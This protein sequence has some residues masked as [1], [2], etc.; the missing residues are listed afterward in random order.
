MLY[1]W[2]RKSTTVHRYPQRR[3]AQNCI[4]WYLKF[5]KRRGYL[6]VSSLFLRWRVCSQIPFL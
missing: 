1:V 2:R 3:S 5:R 4:Q 6:F